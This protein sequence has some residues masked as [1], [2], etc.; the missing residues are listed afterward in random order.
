MALD[1]KQQLTSLRDHL[2]TF[3]EGRDRSLPFVNQIEGLLTGD[4]YDDPD[5]QDLVISVAMYNPHNS[6]C[7]HEEQ[8]LPLCKAAIE[9]VDRRLIAE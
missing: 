9:V 3:V 4:V 5:L 6:E 8:L 1:R 7:L 2:V